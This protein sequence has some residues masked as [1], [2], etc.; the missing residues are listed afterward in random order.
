MKR[1]KVQEKFLLTSVDSKKSYYYITS[2]NPKNQDSG[3]MKSFSLR[4]YN[5]TTRKHEEYKYKKL[6]PHSK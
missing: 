5:P 1:K 2:A 4:K 3:S 6:P